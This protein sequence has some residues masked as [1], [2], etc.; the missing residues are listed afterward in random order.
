MKLDDLHWEL[1]CPSRRRVFYH[2][3][4]GGY[5]S[6]YEHYDGTCDV[7]IR[8]TGG[9]LHKFMGVSAME[10]QCLLLDYVNDP[11][12]HPEGNQ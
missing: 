5:F 9:G 7:L 10:A 2:S 11:V 12:G 3:P 6:V 8:K 4:Q 1:G